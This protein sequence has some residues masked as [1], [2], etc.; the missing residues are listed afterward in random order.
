M[1]HADSQD[2]VR[3]ARTV[4]VQAVGDYGAWYAYPGFIEVVEVRM[5]RKTSRESERRILKKTLL[6]FG[7]T[8][9]EAAET[10]LTLSNEHLATGGFVCLD[11]LLCQLRRKFEAE[12]EM[13]TNNAREVQSGL[14]AQ[15]DARKEV[16]VRLRN[17][18]QQLDTELARMEQLN[19]ASGEQLEALCAEIMIDALSTDLEALAL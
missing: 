9:Q 14:E 18:L 3:N 11:E 19:T 8:D 15:R 5:A 6:T 7:L 13:H 10:V 17:A 12:Q 2:H 4:T 1:V 16:L